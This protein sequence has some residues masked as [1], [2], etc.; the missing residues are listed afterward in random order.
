MR[1]GL[2][3][4]GWAGDPEAQEHKATATIRSSRWGEGEASLAPKSGSYQGA[5]SARG[6]KAYRAE[7]GPSS[8]PRSPTAISGRAEDPGEAD[9]TPLIAAL[10]QRGGFYGEAFHTAGEH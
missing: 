3:L 10:S 8:D 7:A 2:G 6:P 4:Q 5:V 9:H 1:F